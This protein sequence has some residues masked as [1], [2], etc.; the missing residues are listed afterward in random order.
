M[1]AVGT[2]I[3]IA[4]LAVGAAAAEPLDGRAARKATFAPQGVEVTV[5]P[6]AGLA[7]PMAQVLQQV[8]GQQAYYGA[9]AISPDEGLASEATVAAANY[10]D[11]ENAARAALAGCNDRRKAGSAPCVIAA[12]IRPEGWAPRALQLSASATDALRS[13]YRKGGGEKALA[14]SPG[15]AKFTIAKGD[16]AA[17]QALAQCTAA[18]AAAGAAPDCVIVVADR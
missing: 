5:L 3:V 10:H 18:V 17:A 4:A 2:G 15:T 12:E 9:V 6:G 7:G 11:V 8:A 1:R 16:G 13:T 14:V